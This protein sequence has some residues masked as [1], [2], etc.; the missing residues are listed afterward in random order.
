MKDYQKPEVELISLSMQEP[1][2]DDEIVDGDMT[3]ES[4][5]F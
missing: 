5:I 2:T 1:I 3:D 4:S